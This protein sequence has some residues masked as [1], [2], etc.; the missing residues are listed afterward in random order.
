R[1]SR[2]AIE[3]AIARPIADAERGHTRGDEGIGDERSVRLLQP[4]GNLWPAFFERVQAPFVR[5]V[6]RDRLELI[7]QNPAGQKQRR[8][9][10]SSRAATV[11]SRR[12][13]Q[14]P[15]SSQ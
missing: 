2:R 11:P 5:I 10:S 8:Q 13:F 15:P 6:V 9:A 14:I 4:H 1:K 12:N 7:E 3:E